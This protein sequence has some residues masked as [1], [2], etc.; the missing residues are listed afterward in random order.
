MGEKR[1]FNGVL[2]VLL[3]ISGVLVIPLVEHAMA[4]GPV[5]ISKSVAPMPPELVSLPTIVAEPWFKI[6]PPDMAPEGPAFDRDGNLYITSYREGKIYEITPTKQMSTIFSDK[7]ISPTSIAIHKDGRLFICSTKN[8]ELLIMNP[9]GSNVVRTTPK[10]QGKATHI[11]DMVFDSKGNL[12][13]TDWVGTVPEPTGG[14]YRLLAP[15]YTTVQPILQNLAS[16]N[17]ISLSPDGSTLWIGETLR[18]AI[19]RIDLLPDGVTVNPTAGVTYP[20]YSTGGPGGPDSNKVD[21]DGN[22]YQVLVHQGR[23]L[24]LN[25]RGFPLA[26]VVIPG[27]DEGKNLATPNLAFKPGTDEVY[28]PAGGEGG[29]T[30]F[31]FQGLTKGL[32]LFSHQ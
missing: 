13:F 1:S 7:N 10:V 15:D 14:V 22:L 19:L 9:D 24:I 28:F 23:A 4:A 31:K 16:P 18:N 29:A 17:G 11:N 32:T 25:K 20:F 27:R 8:G 5:Q 6:D 26:N 3:A 2:F 12:Y 21:V 30:I